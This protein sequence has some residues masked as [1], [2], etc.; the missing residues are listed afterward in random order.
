MVVIYFIDTEFIEPVEPG[1]IDL[2]SIALVD[3][4]GRE[5][6]AISNEFDP[7][8][9]N[10]FVKENVL[11][12]LDDS[13]TWKSRAVIKQELLDFVVG[14]GEGIE[15]WGEYS[16]YDWVVFC[17]IFGSMVDLPP[18]YP[19]YCNDLIQWMKQLGLGQIPVPIESTEVHNALFDARWNKKA[20]AFLEQKQSEILR[21]SGL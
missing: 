21:G 4:N 2:I 9:A 11:P 3:K 8:K 20:Y 15:F 17:R 6:Y 5:Y 13:S 19:Y 12:K 16:A 18:G 10:E 1:E 14:D 7:S